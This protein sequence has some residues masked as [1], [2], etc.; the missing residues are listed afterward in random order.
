MPLQ[1]CGA[2]EGE[3]EFG[4]HAFRADDVDIFTVSLDDLFHNGQ[5]QAGSAFILAA[6]QVGFVEAFPDLFDAVPG[7]SD[8]CIFY[9]QGVICI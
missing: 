5:A 2:G 4:S 7:N 6:G 9:M 8:A 1:L 3:N